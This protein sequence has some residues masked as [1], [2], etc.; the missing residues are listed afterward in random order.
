MGIAALGIGGDGRPLLGDIFIHTF[1]L[2]H[3]SSNSWDPSL[4]RELKMKSP[5]MGPPACQANSLDIIHP[6]F[7]SFHVNQPLI[8]PRGREVN[9]LCGRAF[10]MRTKQI[11]KMVVRVF[12]A[13]EET[14]CGINPLIKRRHGRP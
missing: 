9:P 13:T 6:V 3:Q 5:N 11:D 14:G 4:L 12:A 10:N 2:F 1:W 7:Y 8:S